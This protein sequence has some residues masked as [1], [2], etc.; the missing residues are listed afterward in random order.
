MKTYKATFTGR[1][2]NAIGIFY[3]ITDTVEAENEEQARLKLFE[4]YEHIQSLKLNQINK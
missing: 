3:K 4:K 2:I 1:K